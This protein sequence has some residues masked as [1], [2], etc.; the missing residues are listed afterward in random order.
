VLNVDCGEVKLDLASFQLTVQECFYRE[1]NFGQ[2]PMFKSIVF[3]L[4]MFKSIVFNLT[5]SQA[6]KQ[7]QDFVAFVLNMNASS[8]FQPVMKDA[9]IL[10]LPGTECGSS[11][12]QNEVKQPTFIVSDESVT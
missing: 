2:I 4:P 10:P 12:L 1:S 9:C 8:T 7:N 6:I 11:R 5:M 3:N